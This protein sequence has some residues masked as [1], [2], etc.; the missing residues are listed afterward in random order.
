M[1]KGSDEHDGSRSERK[2]ERSNWREPQW[3]R[4]QRGK[5][6]AVMK[7]LHV[8]RALSTLSLPVYFQVHSLFKKFTGD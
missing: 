2:A 4:C 3:M 1:C 6:H 8:A 5:S 7:G